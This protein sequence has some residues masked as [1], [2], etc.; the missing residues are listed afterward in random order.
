MRMF[1]RTDAPVVDG[2]EDYSCQSDGMIG[3]GCGAR[4]YTSS[5]HYSFDYAVSAHEIRGI[6]D[7]YTATDDFGR[8]QVGYRLDAPEQRRRHVLQSLLQAAGLDEADY[9]AKF[10]TAARHDFAEPLELLHRHGLLA[11]PASA[12]GD[13][14]RLRLTPQGLAHSDAVG[15]LMFSDPVRAAMRAY[16]A[17]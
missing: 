8:A 3:L 15:P 1:R 16:E 2:G 10:G 4:S 5:L 14:G 12:P 7:D 13:G 6:I 11:A 9:A 17:K